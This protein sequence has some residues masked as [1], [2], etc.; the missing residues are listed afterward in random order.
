MCLAPLN[1]HYKSR[2]LH[3]IYVSKLGCN[4]DTTLLIYFRSHTKYITYI[5]QQSPRSSSS[6][7]CSD[8]RIVTWLAGHRM[9]M[10]MSCRS[11]PRRLASPTSRS[12]YALRPEADTEQVLR[13]TSTEVGMCLSF[14][15]PKCRQIADT[16]QHQ[17]T[18]TQ[19]RGGVGVGGCLASSRSPGVDVHACKG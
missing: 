6:G 14:K 17:I 13:H 2:K 10:S 18:I 11:V 1:M 7:K 3:P 15:S 19:T 9:S 16:G 5:W 8:H 4:S 12:T